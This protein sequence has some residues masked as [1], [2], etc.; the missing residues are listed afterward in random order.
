M[1]CNDENGLTFRL[2]IAAKLAAQ[3]ARERTDRVV[4]MM[5]RLD[6]GAASGTWW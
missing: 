6:G 2:G 4:D 3:R 5:N 1:A